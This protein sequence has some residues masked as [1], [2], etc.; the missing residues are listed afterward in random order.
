[1]PLSVRQQRSIKHDEKTIAEAQ[2]RIAMHKAY[3]ELSNRQACEKLTKEAAEALVSLFSKRHV[4][5]ML[6]RK[7]V[8]SAIAK[9]IPK[10]TRGRKPATVSA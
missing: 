10:S 8:K 5:E 1:M 3:G 4:P 7:V 2:Y 9:A 6:Q